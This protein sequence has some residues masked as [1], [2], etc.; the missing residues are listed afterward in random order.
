MCDGNHTQLIIVTVFLSSAATVLA[1]LVLA[2][3]RP[4][5]KSWIRGRRIERI[6]K[7]GI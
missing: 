7:H 5:I 6:L 4:R 1:I 2:I 3:V